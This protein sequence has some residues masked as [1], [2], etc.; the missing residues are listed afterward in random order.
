MNKLKLLV[1][2]VSILLFETQS[3]SMGGSQFSVEM[4][5]TLGEQ[6]ERQDRRKEAIEAGYEDIEIKNDDSEEEEA[7]C[8]FCQLCR[9]LFCKNNENL[10]WKGSVL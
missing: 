7:G 3:L 10:T 5:R 9:Q 4:V 1:I 2:F 6:Q 8:S